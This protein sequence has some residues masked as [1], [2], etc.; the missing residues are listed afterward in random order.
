[1]A[2]LTFKTTASLAA[3]LTLCLAIAYLFAGTFMVG[4][5]QIE[6]TDGVLLYCRR[7]G[8][9]FLGLSVLLFLARS[10]PNSPA[11][12]AI[13]SGAAVTCLMLATLGIYE[14]LG[15]RA[16]AP[17]LASAA[18]EL[19]VAIAFARHIFIDLR[20]ASSGSR[21]AP[22]GSATTQDDT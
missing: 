2:K 19:F 9:S 21:E 8:A 20:S 10:V 5:W 13:S 6:A 18:L 15:G 16:A 22:A 4:R 1:M 17:I 14:F 7:I 12:R 11:R 3:V